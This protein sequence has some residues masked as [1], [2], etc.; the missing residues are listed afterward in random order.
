MSFKVSSRTVFLLGADLI[1]S[2]GIAL[3]ELIKNAFDAHSPDVEIQVLVRMPSPA[4]DENARSL[5]R[6]SAVRVGKQVAERT[7][8]G[9]QETLSHSVDHTA[10]KAERLRDMFRDATSI[11]ALL[12]ALES[13]NYIEILDAGVGM[14]ATDL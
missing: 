2:D 3:Y 6:E 14:S 12:D 8:R 9:W 5:R 7:L 4:Y 11:E 13:A 1:S 10:P